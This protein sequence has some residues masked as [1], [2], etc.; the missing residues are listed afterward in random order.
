VRLGRGAEANQ[1]IETARKAGW[2]LTQAE[3]V[4]R[5]LTP[6]SPRLEADIAIVRGLYAAT[7]PGV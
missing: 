6:N 7:E 4:W 2:D 5:R 1:H 3:R